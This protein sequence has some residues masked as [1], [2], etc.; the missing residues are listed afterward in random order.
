MRHKIVA[1]DRLVS[2]SPDV[3]QFCLQ[4]LQDLVIR[5]S[6]HDW[7]RISSRRWILKLLPKVLEAN[8]GGYLL[9]SYK[10]IMNLEKPGDR[11]G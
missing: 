5:V 4:H 2:P 3:L 1:L 11:L 8:P 6:S 7:D 9:K 10:Q